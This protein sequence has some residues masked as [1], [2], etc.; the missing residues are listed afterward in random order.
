MVKWPNIISILLKIG[1]YQLTKKKKTY[2]I[3]FPFLGIFF[4]FTKW[5]H[6]ACVSLARG[7]SAPLCHSC[8]VPFTDSPEL[9]FFIVSPIPGLSGKSGTSCNGSASASSPGKSTAG[10][11]AVQGDK[12]SL[13]DTLCT[14]A[15]RRARINA[16]L[17]Q[18]KPVTACIS[19]I[20]KDQM[21]HVHLC[22]YLVSAL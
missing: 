20:S 6:Y 18:V 1:F 13:V 2:G 3:N 21:G 7:S 16:Y 15:C 8:P 5:L 14:A 4:P 12:A 10:S 19:E 9:S 17:S 22:G 11:V